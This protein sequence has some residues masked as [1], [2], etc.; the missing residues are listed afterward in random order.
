MDGFSC[1]PYLYCSRYRRPNKLVRKIHKVNESQ[2]IVTIYAVVDG[3]RN[4][5]IYYNKINSFYSFER[6]FLSSNMKDHNKLLRLATTHANRFLLYYNR[7]SM[8]QF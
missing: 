8:Y 4:I 6:G 7:R 2:Q 5:E 3:R 1:C